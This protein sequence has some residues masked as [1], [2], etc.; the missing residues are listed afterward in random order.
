M[1]DE[2]ISFAERRR[3]L[4]EKRAREEGRELPPEFQPPPQT[5]DP[6]LIPD[7]SSGDRSEEDLELDR[8]LNNIGII[9]AYN[10]WCGKSTPNPGNKRDGIKVSCPNPGHPDKDPSAWLNIDKGAWYC[11]GCEEGGDAYD[12]AALSFGYP[13]PGYKDGQLFHKLREQ[14]AESFGYTI[15][16][17]PG[18]K[19]IYKDEEEASTAGNQ[20]DRTAGSSSEEASGSSGQVDREAGGEGAPVAQ[21]YADEDEN[22]IENQL[23]V[24]PEINWRDILPGDTFLHAYME[25]CSVDDSPEEYHFWHGLLALGHAV[26]RKVTLSDHRPVYG[27]LLVCLLG[28]TGT[29]KSRSRGWL[30]TVIRSVLPYSETGQETTGTKIVS[31]PS[32]GEYLVSAFSYEGRD[33]ANSKIS[34]G[35]Q[36]VNGIVDFDELSALLSRANR[37][38]STLKPTIMGFADAKNEVS[39]GSLTRGDFVAH[40]PFCSITASTQP[41]AIRNLLHRTDTASGFLNRW[42]FAGGSPKEREVLGGV[43]STTSVDLEPAIAQLKLVRGYGGITR[44]IGLDGEALKLLTEFYRKKVYPLQNKDDSDLLKRLDLLFKKLVLLFTVN[45]RQDVASKSEVQLAINLF[46]YIVECYGIL[47]ENIGVTQ[48]QEVASEIMRHINR[49][50]KKTGRGASARDIARYTARRNYSPEQIKKALDV[51]V[52]LNYIE[53]EKKKPGGHIGRPTVRYVAVGE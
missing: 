30:D 20:S 47:N 6:S 31:V 39:I 13:V 8:I 16:K 18:G 35:Y 43:H 23:V 37:Q 27:N 42:V 21:L 36:P 4:A 5:F 1:V 10:K 44:S 7:V 46:E 26:G 15:K 19:L 17:V 32:S 14:M 49:H 9:E 33:P 25:A 28:A 38:G 51:M 50:F 52:A 29:G 12:I 2:P 40:D 11:G 48:A 41:K 45:A 53:L 22:D 24:Y 34:L 3:Q